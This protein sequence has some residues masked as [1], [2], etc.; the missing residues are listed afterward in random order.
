[1][2][3][4]SNRLVAADLGFLADAG[5]I[6]N[7]LQ[8]L[9]LAK[10]CLGSDLGSDALYRLLKKLGRLEV[11]NLN[12][13]G[14]SGL[15]LSFISSSFQWLGL[16]KKLYLRENQLDNPTANGLALEIVKLKSLQILDLAFNEI[17]KQGLETLLAQLQVLRAHQAKSCQFKFLNVSY[18]WIEAM[19]KPVLLEA[20]SKLSIHVQLLG[21]YCG[22]RRAQGSAPPHDLSPMPAGRGTFL[23]SAEPTEL[24]G[25]CVE[26]SSESP[27]N[28]AVLERTAVRSRPLVSLDT[29]LRTNNLA[30][31]KGWGAQGVDLSEANSEGLA[32]LH[33][34]S[35]KGFGEMVAFLLKKKRVSVDVR[36][37]TGA[38]ALYLAAQ[39]GHLDVVKKLLVFGACVDWPDKFGQ[40]PL[41]VASANGHQEVVEILLKNGAH[42]DCLTQ[43]AMTPL[44]L[45]VKNNQKAVVDVLLKQ[46][47]NIIQVSQEGLTAL[48]LAK[49]KKFK[50][51]SKAI[52]KLIGQNNRVSNADGWTPL[53][54]A[55]VHRDPLAVQ[56]LINSGA[57]I[58][59]K[60][61]FNE[62]FPLFCASWE[63][64]T[65]I[66]EILL[67]ANADVNQATR[68]EGRT[69]LFGAAEKGHVQIVSLLLLYNAQVDRA[70][71]DG[72][73]ALH[74]ASQEG[75]LGVVQLL[76][77]AGA[78]VNLARND[79]NTA[80]MFAAVNNHLAV[81]K[82]LLDAHAQIDLQKT[83]G[84]TML[85]L[86][87]AKGFTQ[88]AQLLI[89]AGTPI[90]FQDFQ[91]N[92]A[93]MA[94]AICGNTETVEFLL[95]LDANINLQNADGDTALMA[96]ALSG[97]LEVVKVLLK[98]KAKVDCKSA[99]GITALMAAFEKRH[100]DIARLLLVAEGLNPENSE[101]S[102]VPGCL[103]V[104]EG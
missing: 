5:D 55:I 10:N 68:S 83:V 96:A 86:V 21:D 15:A 44:Y 88:I 57:K 30:I 37:L 32:P 103:P 100:V 90:N 84:F 73:T 77:K 3:L 42:L 53:Y 7:E 79:G 33:I 78:Q 19:E 25:L 40:T 1:L 8:H 59:E 6:L 66:V 101:L 67:K 27:L 31:L 92:T 65:E 87:A 45:A 36:D 11:L 9:S 51:I 4:S 63:G 34:A 69:S 28:A 52:L 49:K 48:E 56:A 18:N 104:V 23:S 75:H 97:H 50:E 14:F 13:N 76:L 80:L 102:W 82:C 61:S 46:N 12:G 70:T 38:T 54:R 85:N 64:L 91:G 20:F 98:A 16:L 74:L 35:L 17:T 58:D 26:S 62:S 60:L 81:A 93:L 94:A 29:A 39:A 22:Q 72:I 41:H 43:D 24:P 2:D 89:E 99:N 71:V 47:P 95:G